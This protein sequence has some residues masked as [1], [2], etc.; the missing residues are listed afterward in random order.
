MSLFI[1]NI[2]N[3]ITA[4]EL[5]DIFSK[6]GKCKINYK[7]AYAFAEY[8]EDKEAKAAK[9]Q[10]Q[11]KE[12]NG[13]SLNIEWSKKSN[14]YED[15]RKIESYP[16]GKCYFCQ[17]SGHYARDCPEKRRSD[18]RRRYHSRRRS[19]S[20][21]RSHRHRRRY[22]YSRSSR[23]RSDRRRR[24]NRRYRSKSRSSRRRRSS[25]DSKSSKYRGRERERER[26]KDRERS[27]DRYKNSSRSG[28]RSNSSNRSEKSRRSSHFSEQNRDDYKNEEKNF[29]N[30]NEN[31]N[32]KEDLNQN[33]IAKYYDEKNENNI[34][35][36]EK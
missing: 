15:K 5:E 29:Q 6:F 23:S 21:S 17:R 10:L 4:K 26:E 33:E 8:D 19:R 13:Q 35:Q 30:G 20:R 9:E 24:R 27:R 7:G 36:E 12:F 28:S 14:H 3:A 18:S 2:A 1:G 32:L 22:S 31:I 11:N 16:R 25:S 34:T